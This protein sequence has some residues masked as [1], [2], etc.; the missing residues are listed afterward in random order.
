M[1]KNQIR[2]EI[3]KGPN[4]KYALPRGK[5]DAVAMVRDLLDAPS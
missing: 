4:G 1:T 3:R 5:L 2:E